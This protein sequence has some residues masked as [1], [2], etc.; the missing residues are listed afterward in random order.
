MSCLANAVVTIPRSH[1]PGAASRPMPWRRCPALAPLCGLTPHLL[2]AAGGTRWGFFR[3]SRALAKPFPW[4][5]GGLTEAAGGR[6]D[7]PAGLRSACVQRSPGRVEGLE[8][9]LPPCFLP[10]MTKLQLP[11]IMCG[12]VPV[13]RGQLWS[14]N[15]KW[16][17]LEVNN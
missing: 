9:A 8:G 11:P 4:R 16:K 10:Q 2:P 15:I 3:C 12:F 6:S 1:F 14:E 17:I 5:P 7:T 13:T